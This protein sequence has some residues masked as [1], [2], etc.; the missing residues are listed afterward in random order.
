MQ[1]PKPRGAVGE[2]ELEGMPKGARAVQTVEVTQVGIPDRYWR[3]DARVNERAMTLTYS[4][5][6][7]PLSVLHP[8]VAKANEWPNYSR[9]REEVQVVLGHI[10]SPF[11]KVL[12]EITG[13]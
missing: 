12:G 1:L 7:P 8:V 4:N 3:Q 6:A 10:H 13:G 9:C 5:L 2:P 11:G